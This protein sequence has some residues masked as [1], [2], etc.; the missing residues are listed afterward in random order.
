M[1]S[2]YDALRWFVVCAALGM[3]AACASTSD[4]STGVPAST[5]SLQPTGDGC[6]DVDQI[7]NAVSEFAITGVSITGQCTAVTIETNLADDPTSAQ[8]ALRIC[9]AAATVAYT[10]DVN[11]VSVVSADGSELAVGIKGAR[12]IGD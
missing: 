1:S 11:S 9:T 7:R 2:P 4:T 5:A 3:S 10:E 6:G 12:C 8:T